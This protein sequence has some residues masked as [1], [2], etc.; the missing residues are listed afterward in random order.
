RLAVRELDPFRELRRLR[1]AIGGTARRGRYRVSV[2]L[3]AGVERLVG[4]V[5]DRLVAGL[6]VPD[7]G[8]RLAPR[9]APCPE[10][11]ATFLRM[12]RRRR[13]RDDPD[14][15]R[16]RGPARGAAAR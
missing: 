16:R 1:R 9:R 3:L 14:L 12:R 10:P 6:E 11:A 5:R 2:V 8:T 4:R 15:P 7:G 13:E